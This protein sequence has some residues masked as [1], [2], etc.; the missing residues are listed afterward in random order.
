MFMAHHRTCEAGVDLGRGDVPGPPGDY[1]APVAGSDPLVL[2][3]DAGG[4]SVRALVADTSGRRL[5]FGRAAG[6]NP[7]ARGLPEA[8]ERIDEA[9][10]AALSTVEASEVAEIV[11]GMAGQG[12]FPRHDVDAV[13]EPVW[14][15]NGLTCRWAMYSDVEVAFAAASPRR[16]GLVVLSGTGAVVG[17]VRDGRLARYLDGAGWLAGDVGSGYW[18]GLRAVR[19]AVADREGRG[20]PTSLTAAVCERFGVAVPTSRGRPGTDRGV[21]DLVTAIYRRAPSSFAEL[22]PLVS[23]AA[24]AGDVVATRLVERAA[25]ALL[26]EVA[27][28]LR[29]TDDL[30]HAVLAGGVLLAPGPLRD[31]V[32][33]GLV[34][35]WGFDVA[36]ARDG[37][38]GAAWSALYRLDREPPASA[39]RELTTAA[40]SDES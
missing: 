25:T 7:V 11:V 34:G 31:A 37:A 8:A 10:R 13:L 39:H 14:R 27:V 22:A 6:A 16:D 18:L 26:D 4:T 21:V 36:E 38:A 29:D 1:P 15:R 30:R 12:A 35:R 5:G 33:H 32:R 23:A 20:D 2:G 19:A 17:E 28:L 3:V 24:V 9:V 40:G